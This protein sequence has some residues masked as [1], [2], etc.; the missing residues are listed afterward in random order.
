MIDGFLRGLEAVFTWLLQASWQASV[1][2]ALVLLLQLALRGRLNP[3]WHHALWL[4]VVAR[5][6]LPVLPESALSLF[7]F[8]PQTPPAITHTV[9]EPIFITA[10]VEPVR[11]LPLEMPARAHP[12]SLYTILA[13]IWLAGA[14]GFLVVIWMVNHRFARHVRNSPVIDDPRLL[15]IAAAAQV[16]LGQHRSLRLIESAQI[17]SP[18]IM[19]IFYPTLLLPSDVRSRFSDEELRFIFLHEFAH[20][21][22]GD[23]VV[24]WL[25]ALLQILHW[26]NPVLWYAFRRMRIDREPATDALVLSRTGEAEKDRYGHVLITLP[27]LVGI[28]EDKDQFKRRFQLIGKFTRGAYGWSLFGVL[29]LAA[30]ATA[31]LTKAK[32]TEAPKTTETTA[33]IKKPA[34]RSPLVDAAKNGNLAEVERL[35]KQT[36]DPHV[37]QGPI[38]QNALEMAVVRNHPDVVKVLLQ[39]GAAPNRSDPNPS[40]KSWA[41]VLFE[42]RN[43][44]MLKVLLEG[45]ANPNADDKFGTPLSGARDVESVRL[46]VQHGANLDPKLTNGLT[47]VES[48]IE[49]GAGVDV[50]NE[51]IKQGAKFDPQGNG[52]GALARAAAR[53]DVPLILMLLDRGVSPNGYSDEPFMQTSALANAAWE[54]SPEA[55]KLLLAR[56]ANPAGDPRDENTPLGQALIFGETKN[57][58]LLIKAGAHDVGDLS[59]A[60]ALGDAAKVGDLLKKGANVNET[61]KLGNT[62][63]YYAVRRAHVE[64]AE[65][66]IAHGANVNQFNAFGM[67]PFVSLR[68]MEM[69]QTSNPNHNQYQ[70]DW[71]VSNEEG[72]RRMEAF[73]ALFAKYPSDSNYRD[74]QGRTA[75]H[76]MAF[77]GNVLVDF[78]IRDKAHPADPNLQDRDGNTPLIL[79]ALSPRAKETFTQISTP[80]NDKTPNAKMKEWNAVAYV[81]NQLI[82]AGAKLDLVVA[83]GK[84]VGELAMEA[85]QKANNPQL[86]SVLRDAGVADNGPPPKAVKDGNLIPVAQPALWVPPSSQVQISATPEPARPEV[87]FTFTMAEIDEMDYQKDAQ[88]MD[89]AVQRGDVSY[90]AG[91]VTRTVDLRLTNGQPGW[92]SEGEV[93]SYVDPSASRVEKTDGKPHIVLQAKAIF[94]GLN[95]DLSWSPDKKTVNS[96]WEVT[97]PTGYEKC[98]LPANIQASDI[99]GPPLLVPKIHV[100][101]YVDKNWDMAP[102]KGHGFWVADTSSFVRLIE[103]QMEKGGD[104]DKMI[105]SETPSRLAVF[106]SA[107]PVSASNTE[108]EVNGQTSAIPSANDPAA[109]VARMPSVLGARLSNPVTGPISS[110]AGDTLLSYNQQSHVELL[111]RSLPG[112]AIL[113]AIGQRFTHTFISVDFKDAPVVDAL[114]SVRSMA[115][116]KGLEMQIDLPDVSPGFRTSI[117]LKTNGGSIDET[118]HGIC[119]MANLQVTR[120][121]Y[122]YVITNPPVSA[123]DDPVTGAG[124]IEQARETRTPSRTPNDSRAAPPDPAKMPVDQVYLKF[125]F[126]EISENDYQAHRSDID[127]AVAKLDFEALKNLV[128]TK[129]VSKPEVYAKY[130]QQVVIST[131]SLRSD[132]I[133]K[134]VPDLMLLNCIATRTDDKISVAGKWIV[135]WIEGATKVGPESYRP[136]VK[137]EQP[138][139]SETLIPRQWKAIKPAGILMTTPEIDLDHGLP[140]Q[141]TN[142]PH[143]NRLFGFVAAFPGTVSSDSTGTPPLPSAISTAAPTSVDNLPLSETPPKDASQLTTNA[144][145]LRVVQ[146]SAATVAEVTGK[147]SVVMIRIAPKIVQ[148]DED[149]YEAHCA[150]IDSAVQRG[151]ITA[152]STLKSYHLL[153]SPAVLTKSGER[154]VLEAVRVFPY[155][156]AFEKEPDGTFNPTDFKRQ[157]LGV[158]FVVFPTFLNGKINF[159]GDL[160]ITSVGRWAQTEETPYKPV[161]HVR[162]A[163]L[164]ELF[165]S[166]QTKGFEV[167]GGAQMEPADPAF[168]FLPD[169]VPDDGRPMTD[170]SVENVPPAT[171]APTESFTIRTFLAPPG[172]FKTTPADHADVRPELIAHGIAFPANTTAIYVSIGTIDLAAAGKIVMRNTPEQLDKLAALIETAAN[173]YPAGCSL[174]KCHH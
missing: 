3:R 11:T 22:R 40:N 5:L 59:I 15:E 25:I 127:A 90:F 129:V 119:R 102:G 137:S 155:P 60:A 157:N 6:V 77:S 79:A 87:K 44:A 48:A 145:V 31:C 148:I 134:E 97:V 24:Q 29:L 2:V 122:G 94:F 39:H 70:M 1:L 99:P 66:L 113:D 121:A 84:T 30:L 42:A 76:Q 21:K 132:D 144:P 159:K 126:T 7:Q 156:T 38:M 169:K 69:G 16:E 82:K 167:P 27:T 170:Q 110:S 51:L 147:S 165:A 74:T 118:V 92:Y 4:L 14:L 9:I 151:D 174:P 124:T 154:G 58:E 54:P 128:P 33:G 86:I 83:K 56:G 35:L 91:R 23:L 173:Q 96:S 125:L 140:K 64:I 85:A 63:L 115:A 114:Q 141:S 18:A 89:D 117:T 131:G 71:N 138:P 143:Q 120:N 168:C 163:P 13:L 20:L 171:P 107:E 68:M 103:K 72:Q 133:G 53:N 152:L 55:V 10:P 81:A 149:D 78:L 17:N 135:D 67:T 158:R 26:F 47:L 61:D 46:L 172:F 100:A 88:R 161:F 37:D 45:G 19:G 43:A 142:P 95:A 116:A 36:A 164:S 153:S 49:S 160:N 136:D 146:E 32:A 65:F 166:G 123:T 8:T 41:H 104:W 12:F 109:E 162:E 52:P 73:K 50:I 139:I 105:K 75:L 62:P 112:K 111:V 98:V 34:L 150:D 106:L 28:L 130:G 80:E 108:R 101:H 93:Q 57:T